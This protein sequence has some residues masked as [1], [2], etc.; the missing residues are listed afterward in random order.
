[1]NKELREHKSIEHLEGIKARDFLVKLKNI[2][3]SMDKETSDSAYID[4]NWSGY[5]EAEL[6][7]EWFDEYTDEEMKKLNEKREKE[8]IRREE[9]ERK[10]EKREYLDNEIEI[11]KKEIKELKERYNSCTI[12]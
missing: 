4:L 7:L 2:L 12:K 10:A 9:A 5:E 11:K 3:D 8:K 1:M 6:S